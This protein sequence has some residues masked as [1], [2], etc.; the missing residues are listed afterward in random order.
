MRKVSNRSD[1]IEMTARFTIDRFY[2]MI[3]QS[4][5]PTIF[6]FDRAKAW[7]RVNEEKRAELTVR[8]ENRTLFQQEIAL[9]DTGPMWWAALDVSGWEGRTME[10]VG[11]IPTDAQAAFQSIHLVSDVSEIVDLYTEANRPQ[12]HF[13]Y[14]HGALGD[15]TAMVYYA[16]RR[17]WHLFTIHNPLRGQEICWGHAVSTDL[18]HWEERAPIFH[19]PH[20][21]FNGVGFTDSG[22]LFGLNT[23]SEQAMV[24]LT[25]IMGREG[26]FVSMTISVD[27]GE[28]F[29]DLNDLRDRLGRYDLPTNPIV[30]GW[31]D[32]P[33]I[34]WNPVAR[35]FFLTHCVWEAAAARHAG[36]M[37]EGTK[38][39]SLASLQYTSSDL[40]RWTRIDDFPLLIYDNWP[41]EG[42]ATDV[43]E[44][45]VD[46][47]KDNKVLLIMCG[48]HGYALGRYSENGLNNLDGVPL[49]PA[50]TI[51][52]QHC[53]FPVIFSGAPEGRGVIMYNVGN[54][55]VAG[56]PNYEIDF[57]PNM[58]F[59]LELSLRRTPDG[60]RLFQNPVS[61]IQQLYR[62]T[63]T[64]REL[65]VDNTGVSVD[66]LSGGLYRIQARIDPG[67]AEAVDIVILGYEIT[68]NAGESTIG[69]KPD[70]F[71]DEA[72]DYLRH[73]A[74]PAYRIARREDR[75]QFDALVDRTS[76]EL[77]P[78][79]G[80]RYIF[81][82]RL[83][84]YE[85]NGAHLT[86]KTRGG[87]SFIHDITVIEIA[88]TVGDR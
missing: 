70:S 57:R 21:V 12:Y 14:R 18:L 32:A 55:R 82:S 10:V 47:D 5:N 26:G 46:G 65:T 79:D 24:L 52:T 42:D 73:N 3:P 37:E 33:R 35:K 87:V 50:D 77:F 2:L 41:G 72:L 43:I 29:W 80:E 88:P 63:H 48:L 58:S 6:P 83:K 39:W 75:I 51:A 60:I 19:H 25:P 30:P 34:H 67:S 56:I 44:L 16:P 59:P 53:G 8:V 23:E 38:K 66:G 36:V 31:G 40:R 22:N 20:M 13:T 61:E 15:P 27:G 49:S 17:E 64:I 78:N 69:G 1:S 11:I 7:T 4:L 86:F 9:N 62:K 74:K 71:G 81:Y 85:H 68:Y 54:D 28:T 45:P 76:I 84:L